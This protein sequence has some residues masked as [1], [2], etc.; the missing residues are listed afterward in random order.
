MRTFKAYFRKEMIESWRQY[1]YV[2]LAAGFILFAITDPL[3]LKFLPVLLKS[4]I[5]PEMSGLLTI[6]Y[7][8]LQAVANFGKDVFQM[9]PLFLFLGIMGSIGD[10]IKNQKLVFPYSKGANVSAIVLAKFIHYAVYVLMSSLAGFIICV[11][12]SNILFEGAKAGYDVVITSALLYAA[13]FIFGIALLFLISSFLKKGTMAAIS[14]IVFTYFSPLL[15]GLKSLKIWI[16]ITLANQAGNPGMF[17]H[18]LIGKALMIT[19]IYTVLLLWGTISRMK[20]V[21]VI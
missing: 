9:V 12:Y 16:P 18:D 17:D 2:V 7:T 19:V 6:K 8:P 14:V 4:Q 1:R 15:A 3:M 5:P 11:Y 10:E 20:K 13:Y 21:E